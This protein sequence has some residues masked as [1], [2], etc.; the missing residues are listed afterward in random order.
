ML[1]VVVDEAELLAEVEDLK[2]KLESH[3]ALISALVGS[4]MAT[5]KRMDVLES[6]ITT[7]S[8]LAQVVSDRITD[9]INDINR[10]LDAEPK[11]P[12]GKNAQRG[13]EVA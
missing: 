6:F 8:K 1:W 11:V 3:K 2:K 10:L 12:A 9:H 4:G 7:T 5:S 13:V